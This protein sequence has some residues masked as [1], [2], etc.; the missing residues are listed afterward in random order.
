MLITHWKEKLLLG[1]F[2]DSLYKN[3][4]KQWLDVI[5]TDNSGAI[6]IQEF[7]SFIGKLDNGIED[8]KI[9]QAF[10]DEDQ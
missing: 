10:S 6:D 7:K 8:T 3:L 9:E 4:A 1:K 5:D 2:E